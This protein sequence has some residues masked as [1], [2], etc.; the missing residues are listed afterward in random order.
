MRSDAGAPPASVTLAVIVWVPVLSIVVDI[1]A[2]ELIVP[3]RFELQ[4]MEPD[5]SPSSGSEAVAAKVTVSP[6][7]KAE[8]S[9][10]ALM[11]TDGKEFPEATSVTRM[12][13]ALIV[14]RV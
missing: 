6:T 12:T 3:S 13:G 7:T 8:P 2:P 11:T 5:K 4:V 9:S 14:S 1:E 10:G